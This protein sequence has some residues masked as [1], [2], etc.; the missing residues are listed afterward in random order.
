MEAILTLLDISENRDLQET[1]ASREKLVAM[2]QLAAG[3]AHELN[4]PLGSILGY[5]Q[6]IKDGLPQQSKPLEFASIIENET[7]RCS[8]IIHDMLNFA[9][10]EKCTGETC[11][12][13][14]LLTSITDT[15][16]SCRTRR[17][18]ID[19]KMDLHQGLPPAEGDCGQLEIVFTNL[20]INA[21]QAV[22]GVEAP[23]ITLRSWR[24]GNNYVSVS[25]EDNGPGI[26]ADIR[27]NIFNPFFTTKDVGAGSGL[28][29]S[30]SQ[31]LLAKR[32]AIIKYDVEYVHGA[33]FVIDLPVVDV[34]RNVA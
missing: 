15:V 13:N 2:G 18:G 12:I 25:V 6:L 14:Q 34:R 20:V 19:I 16:L 10:Q 5:I 27:R 21:I 30:I 7:R 17:Y 32:G 3:V 11:D 26:P 9:N 33:R 22:D 28:G 31:A 24:D 4:T 1:L 8:K 29:L 23:C